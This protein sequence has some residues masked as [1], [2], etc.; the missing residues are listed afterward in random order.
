MQCDLAVPS[1]NGVPYHLFSARSGY[2]WRMRCLPK[3]PLQGRGGGSH[4]VMF[5]QVAKRELALECDYSYEA[6]CQK[7]FR[8]LVM[9]DTD[10]AL[11][12]RVP[13]VVSELCTS[14]LLTTE[15]VPGVHIDKAS[16][17]QMPS[18]LRIKPNSTYLTELC[19]IPWACQMQVYALC[20]SL[21]P[22]GPSASRNAESCKTFGV[23]LEPLMEVLCL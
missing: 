9:A 23:M 17:P 13:D 7:K 11:H 5:V 16:D 6:R 8:E 12:V 18:C 21:V 22:A 15:W 14:R 1:S 3:V 20:L 4:A 10:F 2:E 19:V